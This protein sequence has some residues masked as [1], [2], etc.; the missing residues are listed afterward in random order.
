MLL[1]RKV[2]KKG[3][4]GV[5]E[6]LKWIIYLAILGAVAYGIWKVVSGV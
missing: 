1:R 4:V 2:G 6:V 5:E 3:S